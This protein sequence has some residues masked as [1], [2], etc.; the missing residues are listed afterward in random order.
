VS[1]CMFVYLSGLLSTC[2]SVLLSVCVCPPVCL[3]DCLSACL[4]VYLSGQVCMYVYL[5]RYVCKYEPMEL[6]IHYIFNRIDEI[7][8]IKTTIKVL[9]CVRFSFCMYACIHSLVGLSIY[10]I[11]IIQSCTWLCLQI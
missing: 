8:F 5:V 9:E 2:P 4:T 1:L 6:Y 11:C 3:P 7:V 10:Y